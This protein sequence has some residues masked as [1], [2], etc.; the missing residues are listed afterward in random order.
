MTTPPASAADRA[1]SAAPPA[2]DGEIAIRE[3][4]RAAQIAGT[5]EA[6]DLFIRRHP[7]HDL[8]ERARD[9]L[10]R[11]EREQ[12]MHE[13]ER[14]RPLPGPRDG[15]IA[16]REEFA[17]AILKGEAGALELF[18]RRHPAHPLAEI[19]ELMLARGL[20]GNTDDKREHREERD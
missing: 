12:R 19:A 9:L 16:I 10:E 6:L 14:S 3:E 7:E 8:A 4:F 20:G 18:I 5:R 13:D 17:H 1:G 2:R 15:E 11:L